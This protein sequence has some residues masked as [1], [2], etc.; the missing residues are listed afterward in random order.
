MCGKRTVLLC[1]LA[2]ASLCGVADVSAR[3]AS[4]KG[5]E[6]ATVYAFAVSFS[7][8]DSIMHFTDVQQ[9]DNVEAKGYFMKKRG[10]YGNQFKIW[11]EGNGSPIQTVAMFTY[12]KRSKAVSRLNTVKKRAAKKHGRTVVDAVGFKFR[13]D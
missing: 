12:K 9:L 11:L 13:N 10:E 5:D 6:S 8:T 1:L 7:F 3:E 2:I 4:E